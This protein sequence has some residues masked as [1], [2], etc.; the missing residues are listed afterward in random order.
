[1]K[2]NLQN[3]INLKVSEK[4]GIVEIIGSLLFALTVFL[5]VRSFLFCA[6]WISVW[7]VFLAVRISEPKISSV[8]AMLLFI[9]ALLGASPQGDI[10]LFTFLVVSVVYL[11]IWMPRAM[12]IIPMLLLMLQGRIIGLEGSA[13]G[14]VIATALPFRWI[15]LSVVLTC[16]FIGLLL[17]G[18]PSPASAV[19]RT[20]IPQYRGD[21]IRW[22]ETEILNRALPSVTYRIN[23]EGDEVFHLIIETGGTID[24]AP[25]GF[26]ISSCY[27]TP[28]FPG[29]DTL[30]LTGC[31]RFAKVVLDRPY[32]PMEHPVIYAGPAWTDDENE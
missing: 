25:L 10:L 32:S 7:F 14:T 30:T 19:D 13:L 20:A 5:F 31:M 15:R 28:I 26:L 21:Q 22:N 6:I 16:M 24:A 2:L 27:L 12:A 3:M 23:A 18:P 8:M 11:D 9:G 4:L 1:M 29:R 17:S